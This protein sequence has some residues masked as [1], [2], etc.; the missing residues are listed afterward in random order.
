MKSEYSKEEKLYQLELLSNGFFGE[1]VNC[2]FWHEKGKKS[3]IKDL[4]FIIEPVLSDRNLFSSIREEALQYFE[5]YDIAWWRQYEDHYFPTGH[6]LSSQIH[7]LN[8]LFAIRKNAEAVLSMIQPIGASIG[9]SFDKVLPSFI[10]TNE[11]YYDRNV[12][13]PISNS[14]YISFEFV[15]DNINLLGESYEK[16]GAKCTSVDAIVYAQAGENR[17]LIPIEWK[18]TES[19]DHKIEVY[20]FDRYSKYVTSSS[21]IRQWSID[22]KY[23]PFFEL[24]RQ[25]LLME[26]LI[27]RKPLVGKKNWRHPQYRLIA[28]NFLHIIVVPS[29][30]TLMRTDAEKFVSLLKEEYHNYVK[31]IDPQDFLSPVRQSQPYLFDYLQKRYWDSRMPKDFRTFADKFQNNKDNESKKTKNH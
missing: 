24:G 11:A 21:R 28:D 8:H 27:I 2:G 7:C 25:T 10:D 4:K 29:G 31:I 5:R 18:Y 13:K 30:N 3:V 22:F 1:K 9:V 19:Y 14:N 16:R 6:L 23:E 15:C 17:W 26:Q 12:K 20:S